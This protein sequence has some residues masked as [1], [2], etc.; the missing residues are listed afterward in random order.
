MKKLLFF[1]LLSATL[2]KAQEKIINDENAVKREVKSFH[3]IAV[4]SGIDL[5]IQQGNEEAVAVSASEPKYR[6]KIITVV[7]NGILKIY[8]EKEDGWFIS[9][10]N[11][12]KLKAYVSFRELDTLKGGSGSEITVNGSISSK[13]LGIRL[14]SGASFTGKV[15]VGDLS[16]SQSSGAGSNFSGKAANLT[17]KSSSGAL[18]RGY[19]LSVEFCT[20]R[21]SSG[22]LI[23]VTVN[24]ELSVKATSGGAVRYKGSG[25]IRS[26]DT[27]SGGSVSRAE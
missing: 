14:S 6:E 20:A 24:K 11:S 4:G 15:D 17:V 12:K 27:G 16:V 10:I 7:E 5:I 19:D 13:K 3:G 23:R 8:Y 22:G 1:L 18:F 25:L 9:G 2:V 21:V 26:I